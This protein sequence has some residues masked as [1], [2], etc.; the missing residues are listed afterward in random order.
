MSNVAVAAFAAVQADPFLAALGGLVSFGLAGEL[1]A[2]ISGDRP[3]TFGVE[4]MNALY[5][6]NAD[7]IA[8]LAKISVA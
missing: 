1:A 5:A 6:V 8:K 2:Q 7:D 3:G 4:L